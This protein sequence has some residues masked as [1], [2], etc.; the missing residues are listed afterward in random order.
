V[1]G[2]SSGSPCPAG[3]ICSDLQKETG[4]GIERETSPYDAALM[5]KERGIGR[6]GKKAAHIW[7]QL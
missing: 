2:E 4:T 7:L 1:L 5:W 6:T 3:S